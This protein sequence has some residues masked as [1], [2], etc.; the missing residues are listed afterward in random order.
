MTLQVMQG[1]PVPVGMPVSSEEPAKPEAADF[2][3]IL[4]ALVMP[5]PQPLPMVNQDQLPIINP[6]QAEQ[7]I[8]KNSVPINPEKIIIP[9]R[10]GTLNWQ[11]PAITTVS[12]KAG[13]EA[14]LTLPV[15][16][17]DALDPIIAALEVSETPEQFLVLP[18][19]PR[20]Q[21]NN[22]TKVNLNGQQIPESQIPSTIKSSDGELSLEQLKVSTEE[23]TQQEQ[24]ETIPTL[25]SQSNERMLIPR[26]KTVALSKDTSDLNIVVTEKQQAFQVVRSMTEAG[27]SGLYY[28]KDLE[29]E[30]PLPESETGNQE[31][32]PF[33]EYLPKELTPVQNLKIPIVEFKVPNQGLATELPRIIESQVLNSDGKEISRDFIIHLEPKDLGK[34]TV[35]LTAEEGIIT[36]KILTEHSETRN[37]IETGLSN[38]RQSF[39]EQ[40][41]KYG[42]MEVELGGQYLNQQQQQQKQQQHPGSQMRWNQQG[43]FPGEQWLDNQL[44]PKDSLAALAGRRLNSNSAVDYMA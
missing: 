5:S 8:G 27:N 25:H 9:P 19:S 39:S 44:Y 36:V 18:D 4:A 21:P 28:E 3:N 38:L 31:I 37:L 20:P 10:L 6:E 1:L 7:N 13:K 16:G 30:M 42:K 22:L 11:P 40:G 29:V 2:L 43:L 23:S 34:L 12:T 17:Q 35:K 14:N 41:I 24:L 15:G 33:I 32:R 26:S